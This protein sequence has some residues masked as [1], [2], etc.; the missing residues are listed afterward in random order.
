MINPI[1]SLLLFFLFLCSNPLVFG[2]S[3]ETLLDHGGVLRIQVGE[4]GD[5]FVRRQGNRIQRFTSEGV[6]RWEVSFEDESQFGT[7]GIYGFTVTA[8]NNVWVIG[9]DLHRDMSIYKITGEDGGVSLIR[10]YP[11]MGP[12]DISASPDGTLYVLALSGEKLRQRIEEVKKGGPKPEP[13][14][15]YYIHEISEDGTILRSFSELEIP[16]NS[17][18]EIIEFAF[19]K[20]Q[21]R[22]IFSPAGQAYLLNRS[23]AIL[24]AVDLQT[25][26]EKG[27]IH[28]P[29]AGL[30]KRVQVLEVEFLSEAEILYSLVTAGA[31]G[32]IGGQVISSQIRAMNLERGESVIV[33]MDARALFGVLDRRGNAVR[34]L[35]LDRFN[36]LVA[37]GGLPMKA[38]RRSLE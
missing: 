38:I 10:K 32:R 15:D 34:I 9:L 28:L 1:L 2:Q 18:Q 12:S 27:S 23:K 36:R 33:D 35:E 7:F 3:F 19:R 29:Y 20:T 13:E 14:K 26:D 24:T 5:Y 11:G 16:L 30:A 22:L 4:G 31:R 8:D 25:G 17:P 37:R 6:R 21:D